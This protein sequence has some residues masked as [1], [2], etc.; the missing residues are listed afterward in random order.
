MAIVSGL[1]DYKNF[2]IS[3]GGLP[4][5]PASKTWRAFGRVVRIAPGDKTVVLQRLE[6]GREF[7]SREEAEAHALE[8]A[9]Q[10]VDAQG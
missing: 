2:F 10:W 7:D 3:G 8:L 6:D 5:W 1:L 4:D 9:K